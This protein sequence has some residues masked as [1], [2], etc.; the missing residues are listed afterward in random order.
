MYKNFF[1]KERRRSLLVGFLLL[2]LALIFQ[3]YASIYS[4]SHSSQFVGDFFLDHLPVIDL[5]IIIV[6][7]ALG[8]IIG[9]IILLLLKPRYLIFTLKAVALFIAVRAFF[10]AVTHLGVYPGQVIPS[11]GFFDQIYVAL[12][13]QAG[14]FF[15]AHTGLPFLLG[16][17]FWDERLW[18]YLFFALAGLFGI[19]VLLAH[20]H[21]SI[22]VFAAPFM[23]YSIFKM[24]QYLFS[25]EYKLISE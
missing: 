19:S 13:L 14:Y 20:V 25:D 2:A 22:D 23:T 11:S 4:D 10:V 9:S 24:A 8:V 7:G 15:S 12:N 21:Y 16:L 18:R 17:I 3:H 5:N 6:E 1:T